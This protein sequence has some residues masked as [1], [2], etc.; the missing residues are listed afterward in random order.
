MARWNIGMMLTIGILADRIGVH[1]CMVISSLFLIASFVIITFT[2]Q[3]WAFYLFAIVFSFP[4]GGEVTLIP[5]VIGKYFGTKAMATLM[6][7]TIFVLGLGGAIG[8]WLAGKIFDTTGSYRWAF[9]MGVVCGV[10]SIIL[11]WLL[12]QKDR[13]ADTRSEI[14]IH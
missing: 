5:L 10:G 8:P 1:F 7:M 13:A 6:G 9:I 12:K 2:T 11:I 4:Y 3:V 14:A